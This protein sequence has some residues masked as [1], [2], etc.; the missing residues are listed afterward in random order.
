M[1]ENGIGLLRIP[2]GRLSKMMTVQ[3]NRAQV[4]IIGDNCMNIVLRI[5]KDL[6]RGGNFDVMQTIRR[7]GGNALV[8]SL[9]LARWRVPVTYVG[10]TGDDAIGDELRTWSTTLGLDIKGLIIRGRTRVSY[11]IVD[12]SERTI[13][14]ERLEP[15]H[16]ELSY[17]D[18]ETN[19]RMIQQ[20]ND[21]KA[22]MLDRYC[23]KI[24]QFISATIKRRKESG[25]RPTLV[26]RTGSRHSAGLSV[27]SAILPQVDVC[28]TKASFLNSLGY[29][30][31]LVIS[32]KKL[33]QRFDVPVVV[34]T[35]GEHGA[36]FYDSR[37]GNASLVPPKLTKPAVGTLGG[38]DFFRA[39][40]LV[41]LLRRKTIPEATRWGNTTAGIH[42][43]R[44]ETNSIYSLFFPLNK[45]EKVLGDEKP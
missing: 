13:L 3:E 37:N 2:M 6:V 35:A 33:S 44:K 10:V 8:T 5:P 4:V 25:E 11:A 18:I 23:S 34:A 24:H 14:D 12:Q 42:C 27:E 1:Y 36:A 15:S 16:G 21:A 7:P 40:F 31:D 45:V 19:P 20:V 30:D 41:A 32:C 17:Q 26:Y 28:F 43:S 38:G 29:G 22:I 39:G 9:I